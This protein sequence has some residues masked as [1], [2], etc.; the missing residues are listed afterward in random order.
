[1]IKTNKGFTL[2][3]LLVVIAIIG[4]LSSIVLTSLTS[5]KTKAQKAAAMATARGILPSLIMCADVSANMVA[6]TNTTIGGGNICS[7]TTNGG[8]ALWPNLPTGYTYSVT[9]GAASS[10]TFD[11][12]GTPGNITCNVSAGSCS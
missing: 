1:M 11:V 9:N 10:A 6:P 4:I 12:T 8:T 2:I 3:E 5:A 7:D